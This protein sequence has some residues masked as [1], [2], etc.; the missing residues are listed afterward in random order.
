MLNILKK[1]P[2]WAWVAGI[3]TVIFV[4][5]SVSGWAY[6]RKIYNIALDQLRGDQSAILQ[7]KDE[8]INVC[9]QEIQNLQNKIEANQKQQA[10]LR[11]ENE[12]LKG[13]V[14]D[15]ENAQEN[16]VV[17]TDPDALIDNLRKHGLGSAHRRKR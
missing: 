2:W 1:M 9:E 13:R 14:R 8:W 11:I 6:T 10:T 12:K 17:P 7:G 16:I 5:Q 4:W 15:L 3:V